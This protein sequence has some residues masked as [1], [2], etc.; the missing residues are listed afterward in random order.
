MK[1]HARIAVLLTLASLALPVALAADPVVV[2]S[3]SKQFV[4]RGQRQSLRPM[5]GVRNIRMVRV[6][7]ALL[8]VTCERVKD[9]LQSELGWGERWR[10]QIFIDVHPLRTDNEPVTVTSSLSP[11][12]WSYHVQMPDEIDPPRLVR[13]LVGVLLIEFANRGSSGPRSAELPPWLAEGLSAHLR[14]GPL[15]GLVLEPESVTFRRREAADTLSTVR[16]SLQASTPLSVDQL[17]WPEAEQFEGAA[18]M[19][20]ENCAHLFVRELLRR[21]VTDKLFSA[22][23]DD[24]K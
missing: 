15:A 14:A 18:A 11:E 9:A 2:T 24:G 17:N 7:P 4:V 16:A 21:T 20:Y 6:D 8:A 12:G 23:L 19:L 1:I 10:G 13:M 5:A 22:I 3:R